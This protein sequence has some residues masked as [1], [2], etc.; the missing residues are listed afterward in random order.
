MPWA[1]SDDLDPGRYPEISNP[2]DASETWSGR[3]KQP[4]W[5]V[6]AAASRK[7]VDDFRITPEPPIE[8]DRA[9]QSQIAAS[10]FDDRAGRAS[11]S[12]LVTTSLGVAS[13][14]LSSMLVRIFPGIQVYLASRGPKEAKRVLREH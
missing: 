11:S 5:L 14:V 13:A 6:G 8:C 1:K 9:H 7:H 10:P 12:R 3:G 2:D 4:R